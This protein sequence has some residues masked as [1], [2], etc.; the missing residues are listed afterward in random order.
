MPLESEN[1]AAHREMSLIDFLYQTVV[2]SA[3][4]VLAVA[5]E[6]SVSTPYWVSIPLLIAAVLMLQRL[7]WW[8]RGSDAEVDKTRSSEAPDRRSGAGDG[9]VHSPPERDA[10]K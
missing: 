7:L 4:C 5:I 10:L 3:I 2:L 8:W 1:M 6:R 9:P